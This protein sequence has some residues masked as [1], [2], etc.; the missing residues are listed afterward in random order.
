MKNKDN[1]INNKPSQNDSEE[2]YIIKNSRI[3]SIAD[4]AL[5]E[6]G[7]NLFQESLSLIIRFNKTMLGLTATFVT[8][9]ASSFGILTL[10]SKNL[11]LNFNQKL[12]LTIPVTLM[13]FSSA[14]FMFGYLPRQVKFD[15]HILDSIKL[16]R[17]DLLNTRKRW[18]YLGIIF[19]ILAIFSLITGVIFFL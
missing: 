8:F 17:M 4:K 14:C 1:I 18:T 19:F 12:A 11:Q 16:A 9:M 2:E 13:L 5:F 6:L 10:G 15:L 3:P 7:K